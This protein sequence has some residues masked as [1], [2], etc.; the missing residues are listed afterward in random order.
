MIC[1]LLAIVLCL[2][3]PFAAQAEALRIGGTG[4]S[5]PLMRQLIAEFNKQ[6]PEI[7]FTVLSPSLGS[8]GGLKALAGAKIDL[9]VIA[10]ALTGEEK[11]LFGRQVALGSTPFV[12]V[13]RDGQRRKGFTLNELASVYDGRL[14]AW[15]GGAPIRLVLRT[16]DDSDSAQI[17]AMS[18]AMAEAV[19]VADQRPGMVY[20]DDDMDTLEILE[21]TPGSL[22]PTSLGLLRTMNS[23]LKTLAVNGVIPSIKA[24]KDG[25]YPWRKTLTVVLP[26]APST[27]TEKFADFLHSAKAAEVLRRYDYL[28]GGA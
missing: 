19:M 8:G 21:R 18:P 28:P 2:V 11:A 3:L 22:G 12:L 17:K 5:E 13:T 7:T 24:M 23:R 14:Q 16:R 27:A 1:R 26:L 25:S 4:S 9:A 6:S 10:R 20:G 15:D